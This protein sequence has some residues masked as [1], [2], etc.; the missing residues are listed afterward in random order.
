MK[1]TS[2]S[3]I[4]AARDFADCGNKQKVCFGRDLAKA[5]TELS[6]H[7]VKAWRRDLKAA[8]KTLKPPADKWR[9]R[10]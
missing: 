6:A 10:G 4:E 8:R 2:I 9:T 1:K 5:L 7:E 3:V